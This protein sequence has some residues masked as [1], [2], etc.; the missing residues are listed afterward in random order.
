MRKGLT[1]T[2]FQGTSKRRRKRWTGVANQPRR[3]GS[4]LFL[5][6]QM[7]RFK[8]PTVMVL[9]HVPQRTPDINRIF[10]CMWQ[11]VP[12]ACC[13]FFHFRHLQG[14]QPYSNIGACYHTLYQY[15]QIVC[16]DIFKW[17]PMM[18]QIEK[19]LSQLFIR[20]CDNILSIV[21]ILCNCN[22]SL[23]L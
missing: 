17:S 7:A 22:S 10:L 14:L 20:L 19:I 6:A 5:M 12:T 18:K 21:I 15:Y 2:E 1:R 4:N 16:A 9:I 8:I 13:W 3:K 11:V 23:Y